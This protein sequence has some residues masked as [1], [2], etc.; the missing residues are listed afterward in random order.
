MA[1]V[2]PTGI[3]GIHYGN[4]LMRIARLTETE[5]ELKRIEKQQNEYL[6]DNLDTDRR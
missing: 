3:K 5:N 6:D 4:D 1:K 2:K